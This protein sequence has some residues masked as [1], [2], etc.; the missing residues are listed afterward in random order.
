MNLGSGVSKTVHFD[1]SEMC[2]MFLF[3]MVVFG[4]QQYPMP[5]PNIL[6]WLSD[7]GNMLGLK[8]VNVLHP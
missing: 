2:R 4:I 3:V 6:P 5:V 1:Q 7:Q 8:S